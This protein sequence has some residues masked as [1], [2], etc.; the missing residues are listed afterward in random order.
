MTTKSLAYH[1]ADGVLRI[2]HPVW[3]NKAEDETDEEFLARVLARN[4]E[5][6]AQITTKGETANPHLTADTPVAI[7]DPA[8][9]PTDRT[10]RDAWKH[11]GAAVVHDMDKARSIHVERI[12]KAREPM[13]ADLDVQVIRALGKGEPVTAIEAKKQKLRDAPADPRIKDAKTVEDLK[14]VWLET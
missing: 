5:V 8:T 14:A 1:D 4:I 13:L 2:I 3:A 6:A 11:D 9:I 12:R 10:F 7:I